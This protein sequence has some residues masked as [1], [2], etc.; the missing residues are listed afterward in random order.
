M[1]LKEELEEAR[2]TAAGKEHSGRGMGS[3]G[4]GQGRSACWVSETA[5]SEA[6]EGVGVRMRP[7]RP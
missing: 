6:R 1:G 2:R 3:K 4:R 5:W 7:K